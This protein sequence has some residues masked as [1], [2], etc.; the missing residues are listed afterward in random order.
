MSLPELQA[1]LRTVVQD[2]FTMSIAY[3]F[4]ANTVYVVLLIVAMRT[5]YRRR[6]TYP[7]LVEAL[8]T[9]NPIYA[10][11]ISLVAPAYNEEV[12][13]VDSVRSFLTLHY[14]RYEV[15]VVN[16]GSKD[17][18]LERLREAFLLEYE[19]LFYDGRLSPTV[20]K[21]TYR[22]KLYPQLVVVDKEN[23]GGKADAM[24]VGVGYASYEL[25]CAVDS[26]SILEEDSLIRIAI[27]F[28]ENPEETIAAGGTIRVANGSLVEQSRVTRARMPR[29]PLALF[30]IVE[31]IRAF[32]CGRVG[33]D[34]L[35]ATLVISGAFGLFRTET[36]KRAG[37][38]ERDSIGEDME[39][40]IRMHRYQR[41][42][43]P[44]KPYRV[45]FIPDPVC[46]TEAPGDRGSLGRQR[47]RWQRGLAEC[48]RENA[49][50]LFNPRYGSI[51]FLAFPYFLFVELLGPLVEFFGYFAVA[52]GLGFGL[53]SRESIFLYF[54]MGVFYGVA[55]TVMAVLISEVYFSRYVR[56]RDFFVLVLAA[57]TESLGYRQLN[58]WWRL[59]GLFQFLGGKKVP[60]GA[61]PRSGFTK[62]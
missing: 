19:D 59:R 18:T 45:V 27:P 25:F 31:Y 7:F 36:V 14:P 1:V 21:G 6:R 17:K 22:S 58:A 42:R 10:P 15:I 23:G 5:I 56:L 37:G 53:V 40:V 30:Q 48:L 32:L 20:V 28:I 12:T 47:M 33:W 38:Y 55:M 41:E 61:M 2:F 13:I 49:L 60:W 29:N 39:L 8:K 16:D 24:N 50:M 46:W 35:G 43:E 3:Y 26:D 11:P 57:L 52:A 54:V 34:S 62:S 4:L 44:D 51:G 9:R